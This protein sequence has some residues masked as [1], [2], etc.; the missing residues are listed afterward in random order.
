MILVIVRLT[1]S[2]VISAIVR[3]DDLGD[4]QVGVVWSW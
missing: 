2:C 4:C 1:W 3:V